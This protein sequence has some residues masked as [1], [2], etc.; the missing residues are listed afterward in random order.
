ML[1]GLLA[2]LAGYLLGSIPFGL[3]L[4]RWA[5]LGDVRRIGSG[6]IGAT[7]VLR[8]GHRGLAAATLALDLLKGTL[9]VL[10]VYALAKRAV[11]F[12][13]YRL[14]YLAG[15]GAVLG[16]LFPL[17]LGFHGG[18]GIATFIGVL[19]GVHWPAAA[20]FGLI[21]LGVAAVWRYS[22]LAA[23]CGTAGVIVYYLIFG[24]AG[25]PYVLVMAALVTLKHHANIRR[26][27]AGQESR[28]GA[29]P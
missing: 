6:N 13:A 2:L 20:V 16:H 19:L 29:K 21:W 4:T 15:L 27:L 8:T 1:Y 11:G 10:I 18:K 24:Q 14:T 9:A 17:W 22:S 5:G 23:L 26:L 7:N 3:L 12:E 28:I 25:L